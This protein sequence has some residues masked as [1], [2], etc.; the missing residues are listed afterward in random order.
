MYS[1]V[2]KQRA[3]RKNIF[4]D[5]ETTNNEAVMCLRKGNNGVFRGCKK[6][7]KVQCMYL[8]LKRLKISS[9]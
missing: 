9:K 3:V 8:A 5:K 6:T 4:R 2:E 7:N 1:H